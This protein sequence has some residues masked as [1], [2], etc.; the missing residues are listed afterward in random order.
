MTMCRAQ[1]RR[2]QGEHRVPLVA[3]GADGPADRDL[4]PRVSSGTAPGAWVRPWAVR[5]L[6]LP[7]A[8]V[9][10]DRG[11]RHDAAEPGGD[12]VVPPRP[13]QPGQGQPGRERD[14]GQRRERRRQV[15]GGQV[16]PAGAPR[17]GR[18]RG[19]PGT[20]A[21]GPPRRPATA[22]AGSSI[23][24]AARYSR[25]GG[26]PRSHAATYPAAAAHGDRPGRQHRQRPA[27]ATR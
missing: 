9:E 13:H 23:Q 12:G 11:R 2:V 22:A 25:T 17:S 27:A 1:R 16:V 15:R 10:G 8:G 4:A 19:R 14:R 7:L 21:P 26:Q 6:P 20:P 24:A 18:G 5:G 3:D